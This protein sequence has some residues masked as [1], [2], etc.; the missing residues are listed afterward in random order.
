MPAVKDYYQILGINEK[1]TQAD[2]KKAYRQLA[3]K[4][5]PDANRDDPKAAERFKEISE[6]HAVLADPEK[7]KQYDTMR[8]Y[9]AFGGG[10]W[11][12]GTPHG[13]GQG[14][15]GGVEFGDADFGGFGGF[16]GLGDLFSSIFGRGGRRA[17]GMEAIEASIEIP[18]RTA[19]LGGKV[20]VTVSV[21]EACPAC[22]GSGAAPGAKVT[23][24]TECGGKGSV[25]FGAGGFAVN[26]PCPAC[27][28]RGTVPSEPCPR[29]GGQAEVP[30]SKRLVVTVPPGTET[31][32]RV[33]LRGQGQ[34]HPNGLPPGDLIVTFQVKPDRFFRRGEGLDVVATVPVNLAQAALGT[35]L[36]VRTL[37]GRRVVLKVPAG[38][39]PGQRFRIR[40]QGIER[41][42]RRGDL[43]VEIDVKIP[44]KLSKDEAELMKRFADVK[45][46]RY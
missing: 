11:R 27:R 15:P 45:G 12:Q 38:T 37:D 1:A 36:K 24:C 17:A 26:R 32:R 4:Y 25:S 8:K 40:G 42:G 34:R 23:T 41:N 3:K 33:R 22:G 43:L 21:T 44:E 46:L 5:H 2:I 19:A 10:R 7:R 14:E 6:A 13:A 29:C 16:S 20:P 28:G 9:G 18:F 35:K 30:V 39:Q 31:G